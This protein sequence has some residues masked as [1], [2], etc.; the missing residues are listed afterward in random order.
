MSAP[1]QRGRRLRRRRT[2]LLLGLSATALAVLTVSQ[3]DGEALPTR[4]DRVQHDVLTLPST[5]AAAVAGVR[6]HP[7]VWTPWSMAPAVADQPPS[8]RAAATLPDGAV[9]VFE[10]NRFLVAYYGTAGTGALGVLGEGPPDRVHRRLV[11]AAAPFARPGSPVQP[12]YEL[13]VTVAD[14]YPG[15]DGDYNHDIPRAAVRRYIDAAHRNGALV[16]LDIQPG[17]ANFL[18]VAR[19]WA[20]ALQDPWV[21]LALDPEW[22]MGPHSVPGRVIGSVHAR[23]VNRV[24]A[25]LSGLVAQRALPEKLFVLHQFRTSMLQRPER[26]VRRPGLALVQHVDGFG[27]PGQKLDTYRAVAR[28]RQFAMGF[29]LFYD[30]D[31]PRMRA[32][33][34]RR[35][36]PVVRFVS[37]Q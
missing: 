15:K 1:S 35:V 31:V 33:A 21:G 7:V 13:I 16:V 30:E 5:A 24:S 27:T 4:A 3:P 36:R 9:R 22:R 20:W 17:R 29:K 19:R 10:G 6:A 23:E 2:S 26:I 37:F 14:A 28:P 32:A 11:R 18:S 25:W 12:V 34:V 8:P